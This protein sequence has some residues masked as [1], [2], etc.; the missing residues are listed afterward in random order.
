MNKFLV[1]FFLCAICTSGSVFSI[2]QNNNNTIF[3]GNADAFLNR[4]AECSFNLIEQ[5]LEQYPPVAGQPLSRKLA[6]YNLDALLHETRYDQNAVLHQFMTKRIKSVLEDLSCSMKEGMKIYKLYN[7]GFVVCTKS[8]TFAFDLCRGDSLISDSLIQ[9][10]V[11]KC[12]ILF[13]SHIHKD[14][15]DL[16]VAG[17][18]MNAG[19]PVWVPAN[20]WEKNTAVRHIRSEKIIEDKIQIREGKLNIIVLPGHQDQL[21]NNVYNVIT[22]EGFS[23]V[24]TGDQYNEKDFEWISQL[25]K[26]IPAVD[27]LLVNC[28]TLHLKKLV[29]DFDPK[30]VITGHEN[31]IGHSIDHREPYWLSFQ[32]LK[33]INNPYVLMTWG[34]YYK[35][36]RSDFD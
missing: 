1:N 27:V 26:R 2:A 25:K 10:V 24:H 14:H 3:W 33:H 31:E 28:W 17:M 15:A 29:D 34:E 18:F 22:S 20:L 30:L 36:S 13:I 35:Y 19:K 11:D 7:D 5:T 9:A 4:Q 21:I 12:D 23:I 8:V 32:K 6:L 16:K